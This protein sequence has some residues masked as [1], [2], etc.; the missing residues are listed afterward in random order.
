MENQLRAAGYDPVR[1]N[2]S[3]RDGSGGQVETFSILADTA[4]SAEHSIVVGGHL[5]SVR[6]GSGIN[7]NGSGVAAMLEIARWMA[8]ANVEAVNRVRFAFW[9]G[10]EDGLE[11]SEHYVDEMSDAEMS[12][13]ALNLNVDMMASPNGVRYV[14]DG[15]GSEYDDG[16]P[17][18]SGAIEHLFLGYFAENGMEAEATPFDGGSDYAAFL[19]AGIPVGGLFTGDVGIKTEEQEQSYGGKAG[20]SH[21]PC[22]HQHCDSIGNVNHELL[23]EM[24]GAL[25]YATIAYAMAAPAG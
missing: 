12:Q 7:D 5:D 18:G 11:G 6:S 24:A 23:K 1:H 3:Y 2:F 8:E 25:A 4:G 17:A 20:S 13:T 16:A 14:H 15:D 21:D 22:Y 10:E 19:E 9:G